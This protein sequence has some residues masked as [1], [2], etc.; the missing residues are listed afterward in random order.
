MSAR[1]ILVLGA[2]G[3]IGRFVTDDLRARDFQVVGIARRFS[4]SQQGRALDLELPILSMDSVLLARLIGDNGIRV[5]GSCG[6]VLQDGPGGGTP[7]AR[8]DFVGRLWQATR[9]S[10]PPVRLIHIS[11]PGAPDD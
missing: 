9:A 5:G 3:L 2:S 4:S 8:R 7:P 10:A 1:N 6:A 11:I